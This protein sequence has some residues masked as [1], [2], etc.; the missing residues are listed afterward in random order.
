MVMALLL[1][2]MQWNLEQ[3]LKCRVFSICFF[4]TNSFGSL[5]QHLAFLS[6]LYFFHHIG[7]FF[8][9]IFQLESKRWNFLQQTK[10]SQWEQRNTMKRIFFVLLLNGNDDVIQRQRIHAP[11]FTP[12]SSSFLLCVF[13]YHWHWISCSFD[14]FA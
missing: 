13:L 11:L 2:H 9:L 8:V 10:D 4:L 1:K 12:F 6:Q 5:I 7:H 14:L 3:V